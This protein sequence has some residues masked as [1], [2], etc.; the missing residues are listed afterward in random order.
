LLFE[1]NAKFIMMELPIKDNAIAFMVVFVLMVLKVVVFGEYK[2]VKTKL[3][4][5]ILCSRLCVLFCFLINICYF[6]SVV[7]IVVSV[8]FKE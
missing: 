7:P 4:H 2:E 1:Y 3:N 5:Q 8:S 6:S